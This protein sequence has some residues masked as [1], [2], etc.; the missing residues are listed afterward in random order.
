[1]TLKVA[2]YQAASWNTGDSGTVGGAITTTL[3]TGLVHEVFPVSVSNFIG[4]SDDIR[5]QKI[6][7][8]NTGTPSDPTITSA[9]LFFNNVKYPDQ[10]S[11]GF[12]SSSDTTSSPST[13]PSSVTFH[14]PLG[15]ANGTGIAATDL[16]TGTSNAIPLWLKQ[17][18]PPNL[19]A[20]TGATATLGIAGQV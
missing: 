16:A 14:T 12:G 19:P 15:L 13:A 20:D 1:M 17:S 6:F 10:I 11:L 9:L 5:Y 4:Q 18:I 8:Q 2:F 3:V 7:I